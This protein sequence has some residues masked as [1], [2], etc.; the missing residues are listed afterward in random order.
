M[1]HCRRHQKRPQ[2][3]ATCY[4]LERRNVFIFTQA[5]VGPWYLIGTD[6][7]PTISVI[8]RANKF[9]IKRYLLRIISAAVCAPIVMTA[10][11]TTL[12][13]TSLPHNICTHSLH[14]WY[15]PPSSRNL[16]TYPLKNPFYKP[17][18][19]PPPNERGND[20][21]AERKG[22]A[23]GTHRRMSVAM[24]MRQSAKAAQMA[25]TSRWA[26][27][28]RWGRA[29][30]RRRWHRRGSRCWGP[31]Q[32]METLRPRTRGTEGPRDSQGTGG[33]CWEQ[34]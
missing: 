29:Q 24:T 23:D 22:G 9:N 13:H 33:S 25:L 7:R 3:N 18:V 31:A 17:S 5:F 4:Q 1:Q 8:I 11:N 10:L 15:C 16:Q 27:Q 19:P 20:D 32:R 28:W 6:I 12:V 26:W 14:P 34:K 21:E 2:T 30:R